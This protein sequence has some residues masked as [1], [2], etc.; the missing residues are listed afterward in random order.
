VDLFNYTGRAS[1]NSNNHEV[2]LAF[3][4]NYNLG[5]DARTSHNLSREAWVPNDY[6]RWVPTESMIENYLTSD[7]KIWD[8]SSVHTYEDVFKNRDP[9]MCQS[10]LAPGTAWAG[11]KDGNKNNSDNSVFTYP[12]LS[13]DKNG[14][15]TYTGYYLRKYVEPSTVQYVGHDDNDIVIFR[16]AEI[17]LN[18]AEAKE[19]LGALTQN[20]LDASINKLRD[21]VGMP[22]LTLASI[23]AG[24]DIRTEIRRER[25]VELFFEGHRYFDLIRWRE[26][27]LL[28]KDLLGVKKSWLDQSK[29]STD[30]SSLSWKTVNGQ[31][32]LLLETN[33]TFDPAKD[34]LLSLPFAQM[35]MNPNLKPNNPGWD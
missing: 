27:S 12:K 11:G 28:S 8:P 22:H 21:R 17:L 2:I 19:E 29:L 20:D 18:Y 6:A 26:G 7:G 3:I 23:P 25:S 1:R 16:Y 24:S 32:Y 14:C 5:E 34:Y 33:R 31:D 4:Y 10:I 15:M 13:N 9:R 35:Q 30:L